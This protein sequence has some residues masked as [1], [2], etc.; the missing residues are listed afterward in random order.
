M[1]ISVLD[2]IPGVFARD[3]GLAS[4][5]SEEAYRASSLGRGSLGPL[6]SLCC[7]EWKVFCGNGGQEDRKDRA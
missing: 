6:V 2:K 5:I 7:D 3:K 1:V 4:L